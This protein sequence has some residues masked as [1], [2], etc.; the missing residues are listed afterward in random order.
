MGRGAAIDRRE[1][2]RLAAWLS[3]YPIARVHA[4]SGRPYSTLF[5]LVQAM[6]R[7]R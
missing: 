1:Y 6:E 5:K 4:L 3:E 7:Q 2:D